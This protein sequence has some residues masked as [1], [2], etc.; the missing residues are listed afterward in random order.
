MELR[1]IYENLKG[2]YDS[3]KTRLVDD[4]RITKFLIK[5][6]NFNYDELIRKALETEDY[7]GAFRESHNLKGICANLSL[8]ALEESA[9]R[10]AESLRGGK[11]AGD[12]S[13][14]LETLQRD[15]DMTLQALQILKKEQ[16]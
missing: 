10:L 14:L 2:D 3:V 5:F 6:S 16:D 12:I 1:P 9:N 4:E 8:D 13:S 15:Y 11:P 7:E